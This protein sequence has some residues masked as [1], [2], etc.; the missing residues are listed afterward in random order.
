MQKMTDS[1][2]KQCLINNLLYFDQFCR[3]HNIYYVLGY[4][5]L[6]GAVRHNG[7]IPWDDDIDILM[8]RSDYDKLKSLFNSY[9]TNNYKFID[10]TFDS[11]YPLPF[12]KIVDTNTVI[13]EEQFSY[14][15]TD[16]GLYIDVFPLDKIPYESRNKILKKISMY[17]K[18]IAF[19]YY[20]D[21]IFFKR[22]FKKSFAIFHLLFGLKNII[23]KYDMMCQKYNNDTTIDEYI[24]N[25]PAY[26]G[27][28]IYKYS[29]LI[30]GKTVKFDGINVNIPKNYDAILSKTYGDYMKIPKES[31]RKS[32]H[33]TKAYRR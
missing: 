28:E 33:N 8:F 24:V 16:Y 26:K 2:M 23:V 15:I 11:S 13:E 14:K 27:K 18:I 22:L 29:D 12:G 9:S 30:N 1:E 4:G 3:K 32:R 6:I 7:M 19:P 20:K 25:W 21:K 5:S 17:Q 31:D 10:Y